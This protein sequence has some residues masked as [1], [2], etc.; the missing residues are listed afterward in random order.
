LADVAVQ[1]VYSDESGVGS[2]AK[3]PL[4]VVTAFVINMDKEWVAVQN[5]LF[6]IIRSNFKRFGHKELKGA[7]LLRQ[8]KRQGGRSKEADR[9]LKEV[10]SISY[11]H[12]LPI[13]YGAVHR[14]NFKTR[15]TAPTKLDTPLRW[16]MRDCLEQIDAYVHAA[17]SDD[18]IMWI[19]DQA[20]YNEKS[21]RREHAAAQQWTKWGFS[22]F[23]SE[24][25]KP[26]RS[27]L[28]DTMYFGPSEESAALQLADVCGAVVAQHLC[29]KYIR[30]EPSVEP[31]YELIRCR[32]PND[33]KAPIFCD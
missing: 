14:A 26:H 10:L 29:S 31:Y 8:I 21:F 33:G 4:T 24:R 15:I 3:E 19:G 1:V 27:H 9:I 28:V 16:A 18:K 5:K 7:A 11:D 30:P 20:N 25:R 2:E 12:F 6:P 22:K 13:F 17:F 23:N 32:I